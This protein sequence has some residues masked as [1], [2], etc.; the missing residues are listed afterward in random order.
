F[1]LTRNRLYL[2]AY[3]AKSD[4]TCIATANGDSLYAAGAALDDTPLDRTVLE[5]LTRFSPIV[6]GWIPLG[7]RDA[8]VHDNIGGFDCKPIGGTCQPDA[9]STTPLFT[10]PQCT[11]PIDVAYVDPPACGA[12]PRFATTFD[13]HVFP[14]GEVDL[15]PLFASNASSDYPCLAA[16]AIMGKEPHLLGDEIHLGTYT[17]AALR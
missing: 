16:P 6:D 10:D 2:P 17:E 12:P 9:V 3:F 8:Y 4:G 5:S 11:V 1:A 15:Q 13:H 14:I 7:I